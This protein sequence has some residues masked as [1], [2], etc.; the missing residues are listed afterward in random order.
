[1][2]PFLTNQP[3]TTAPD[4]DPQ[5]VQAALDKLHREKPRTTVTIAHRLSTIQGADKIAVID[6]GVV[7]LGTH[8]ELIALNGIYHMLCTSQV[9]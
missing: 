3:P 5:V 7:E 8:S 4:D 1:P 2:R 9:G 6:K